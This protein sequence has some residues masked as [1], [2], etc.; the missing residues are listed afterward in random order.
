MLLKG[1]SDIEL[2]TLHNLVNGTSSSPLESPRLHDAVIRPLLTLLSIFVQNGSL[3]FSRVSRPYSL[4]S[5]GMRLALTVLETV[6]V[7]ACQPIRSGHPRRNRATHPP[8]RS[9]KNIHLFM[10]SIKHQSMYIIY[11]FELFII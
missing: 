10:V 1:M 4:P 7:L 6:K 2:K 11:V 8:P 5:P 9:R 3:F